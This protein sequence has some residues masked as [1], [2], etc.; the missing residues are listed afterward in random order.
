MLCAPAEDSLSGAKNVLQL[1]GSDLE[2]VVFLF[3]FEVAE[4]LFLFELSAFFCS[5]FVGFSA[6]FCLDE[7]GSFAGF[8]SARGAF[9]AASSTE[10][11]TLDFSRMVAIFS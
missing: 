4:S 5:G 9:F 10:E 7:V 11:L 8:A 2:L 1:N 3:D 6:G